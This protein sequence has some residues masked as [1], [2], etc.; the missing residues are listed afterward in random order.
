M[1]LTERREF[2]AV[3]DG[4]RWWYTDFDL[5]RSVE[6]CRHYHLRST[7]AN[8]WCGLELMRAKI[9]LKHKDEDT[10]PV[11][12]GRRRD[13]VGAFLKAIGISPATASRREA[14]AK[15]FLSWADIPEAGPYQKPEMQDVVAAMDLLASKSFILKDFTSY[16][17]CQVDPK[18]YLP[19]E[20]GGHYPLVG[21]KTVFGCSLK[22]VFKVIRVMDY[23][24]N[25]TDR[26]LRWTSE[27]R[28]EAQDTLTLMRDQFARLITDLEAAWG[29]AVAGGRVL[30]RG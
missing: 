22:P 4:D 11:G 12:A 17:A 5:G 8:L 13:P 2:P 20:L 28:H 14:L 3:Q 25:Q 7:E 27:Q 1:V 23:Q 6:R 26:C 15:R 9:H 10:S 29:R 30:R 19:E 18:E 16:M 24:I 21:G